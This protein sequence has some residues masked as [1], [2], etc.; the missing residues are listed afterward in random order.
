[1]PSPTR[2]GVLGITRTTFNFV[3]KESSVLLILF[4]AAIVT[5]IT[6]LLISSLISLITDAYKSGLIDKIKI[7]A[8]LATSL[9]SVVIDIPYFSLAFSKFVVFK[10]EHMILFEDTIFLFSIPPIIA[11]P[12]FPHP[13]NP[14]CLS[15]ITQSCSFFNKLYHFE[16]V[17]LK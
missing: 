17:I 8:F 12:I 7:S 13:M 10:S 3:S 9:L 15:I 16:I 5:T 14:I 2:A 1:M 4:P 6:S 11:I